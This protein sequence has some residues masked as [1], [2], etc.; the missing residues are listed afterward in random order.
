[1]Q[2]EAQSYI[3]IPP[4][5]HIRTPLLHAAVGIAG[6]A[7]FT[8]PCPPACVC[9]E[10]VVNCIRR[11]LTRIP[12]ILLKGAAAESKGGGRGEAIKRTQVL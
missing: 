1:M 7:E 2:Q 9:Y 10:S 12:P 11:N 3:Y 4:V 5:A 6:V 8:L